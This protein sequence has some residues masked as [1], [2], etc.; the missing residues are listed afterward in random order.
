MYIAIYYH[1]ILILPSIR[2]KISK[3]LMSTHRLH[4]TI[5]QFVVAIE[6]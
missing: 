1:E 5:G 4:H 3:N 6:P 2:G